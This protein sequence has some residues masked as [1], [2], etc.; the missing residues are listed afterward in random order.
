[1][2]IYGFAVLEGLPT[3]PEV[4][5]EVPARLGPIRTSNFGNV[6]DVRSKPDPVS[7]AYTS[8]TLPLHSD[9]P[10]REY[11]AGLQF[12][13]CLQNEATGGDS[14]LADGFNISRTLQAEDP[15][16]YQALTTIPLVAY[17]KAKDTDYRWETPMIGLND[18]GALDEVRWSPW[19]RA[20]LKR[21][22]EETDLV[23]RSLRTVYALAERADMKIKLRLKPGDLL[24]FDNRRVLHGRKGYD[25]E[26]G[27]RWLRG[28]YVEREELVSR[29][30]I[31]ARHRRAGCC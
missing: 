1:M 3:T 9:L 23:Y 16:A 12:L 27:E 15:E 11:S 5:E 13:H 2:W 6:F 24:G 4:I 10:T 7:N 28:C 20:P 30:R 26:T 22:F 17:N 14:I 29:L 8:M 18:D 31:V 19:L 21:S 25:P